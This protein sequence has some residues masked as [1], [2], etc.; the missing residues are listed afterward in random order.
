MD[1]T[2][3]SLRY[4]ASAWDKKTEGCVR[5]SFIIDAEGQV[6]DAWMVGGVDPVLDGE[7]IRVINAMPDWIPE[8]RKGKRARSNQSFVI[9]IIPKKK[10]PSNANTTDT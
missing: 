6:A 10:G 2:N 5:C 8:K 7:A 1:Y 4:P 3:Q 9:Q